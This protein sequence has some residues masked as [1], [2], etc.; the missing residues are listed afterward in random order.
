MFTHD[1]KIT[2]LM[3]MHTKLVNQDADPEH[4]QITTI[5]K[6]WAKWEWGRLPGL[7]GKSNGFRVVDSDLRDR[8]GIDFENQP[9]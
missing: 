2:T 8:S 1:P 5:G 4:A 7:G 3:L 6:T 9:T